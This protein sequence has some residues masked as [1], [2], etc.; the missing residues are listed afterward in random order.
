MTAAPTISPTLNRPQAQFLDMPKKFRAFV[1]G[2]GSGKTWVG[3]SALAKHFYEHPRVNAGYFAPTYRDIRDVFYPTVEESVADWG[4][5]ARVRVGVHE[6]D[7]YRGRTALGTVMCRSMEDPGSIVG[8]K[9]GKALVDEIDVLPMDKANTAWRKIQAR[10][11]IKR[12]GLFPGADVTT[13][14]EGFRFA[15]HVF[16]KAVR[17]TPRLEG[18]FGIVHASTYDNEINL[19][20]DYIPS[21]LASYPPQLISAYING[22]FVNLKTGSVYQAFDREKN[23]CSDR[24]QDGEIAYVG[25]DF[26]VGKMAAVIHVKRDGMP[27]AVDEIVNGYDTPDMIRRLK[28]RLWRHDGQGY[29]ATRQVRVYP[30]ASGDSRKSVNASK[31]DIALLKE[32][33]FM[34]KA[35][36]TNPPIKDRVNAMNGMFSNAKGER[37][38]FVNLDTCPTYAEALEQQAWAEKGEPDKTSGHDHVND[39][40]GYFIHSEYPIVRRSMGMIKTNL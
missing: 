34:V 39:A 32:A 12:D 6:V 1:A 40:A 8:F 30:D 2:Y 38:Y 36:A 3:C 17:E 15:Y 11:R 20:E 16:K 25:M 7:I 28:D 31:T 29:Q 10:L 24:L 4:L 19:P 37:R 33:G 13:T 9:I 18:M 21:L 35:P 22:Q 27:R 5:T 26:N 14:P 23:A